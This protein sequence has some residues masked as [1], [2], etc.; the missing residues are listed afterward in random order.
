MTGGIPTQYRT[1]FTCSQLASQPSRHQTTSTTRGA[2]L[3]LLL[4]PADDE[5]PPA[6]P[7]SWAVVCFPPIPTHL[8]TSTIRTYPA[9]PHPVDLGWWPARLAVRVWKR[10]P[11]IHHRMAPQVLL[12]P[13]VCTAPSQPP[14]S[15]PCI[16]QSCFPIPNPLPLPIS[17]AR[18]LPPLLTI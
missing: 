6:D 5:R 15:A 10:P 16:G 2:L 7:A 8:C 13:S 9:S 17:K 4:A 14:P 12:L 18:S 3:F 1:P 11:I